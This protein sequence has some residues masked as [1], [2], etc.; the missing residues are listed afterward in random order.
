MLVQGM[1]LLNPANAHRTLF[2][3]IGHFIDISYVPAKAIENKVPASLKSK[4]EKDLASAMQ[5]KFTF[6]DLEDSKED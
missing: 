4:K 6:V 5:I 2:S 3:R 1:F